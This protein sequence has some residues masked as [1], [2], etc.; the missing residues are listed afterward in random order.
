MIETYSDLKRY[1][2]EDYK[3]NHISNGLIRGYIRGGNRKICYLSTNL[4]IFLEYK[5]SDS[6]PFEQSK[7][8]KNAN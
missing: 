2:A 1:L 4:R 6:I 5:T 3:A 7:I 8:K